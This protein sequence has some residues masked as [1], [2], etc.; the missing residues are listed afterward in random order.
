[1]AKRVERLNLSVDDIFEIGRLY[2][3]V[4]EVR[5]ALNAYLEANRRGYKDKGLLY[6][7]I[8]SCYFS[9]REDSMAR[10]YAEWALQFDPENDYVKQ[11]WQDVQ[12]IDGGKTGR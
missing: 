4:G 11:V 10:K 5:S 3:S 1:M 12:A 2:H 6:A 7:C 8:G 9:L